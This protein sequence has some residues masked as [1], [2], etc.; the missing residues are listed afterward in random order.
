MARLLIICLLLT[1][2]GG[3][4]DPPPPPLPEG[5][6]LANDF[7]GPDQVRALAE[8]LD[9]P[10]VIEGPEDMRFHLVP[11]GRFEMGR[12]RMSAVRKIQ[13]IAP[14]YMQQGEV[15]IGQWDAI[16]GRTQPSEEAKELHP[17]WPKTGVTYKEAASFA[18]KAAAYLGQPVRLPREAE[19]EFACRAGSGHGFWSGDAPPPLRGELPR[20]ITPGPP[21]TYPASPLGLRAMHGN[22]EEW[23]ADWFGPYPPHAISDPVGPQSGTQRVLRGGRWSSPWEQQ[24]CGARRG[25][26]PN[27]RDGGVGF[28]LLV[29]SGYHGRI[30]LEITAVRKDPEGRVAE[31]IDGSAIEMISIRERL[32]DRQAG[33]KA[34]WTLVEARAPTTLM[35]RQG[36]YYA[37][38]VDAAGR[39]G[40]ELKI[41]VAAPGPVSVNLVVPRVPNDD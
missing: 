38:L 25:L 3:C 24:E 5:Y 33:I 11:A 31:Q 27:A 20:P 32:A 7:E 40:I 17:T 10:L 18:R 34:E 29:E 14:Y 37:R 21:G 30:P 35:V 4:G 39:R 26:E 1:S 36:R 19:W 41:D 9:I 2:V 16:L 22:V 28:R 6:W 12:D 8:A 13:I 15:T 23:C